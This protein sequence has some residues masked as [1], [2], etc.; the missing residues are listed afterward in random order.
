MRTDAF[1]REHQSLQ[2]DDGEMLER[3]DNAKQVEMDVLYTI[4]YEHLLPRD[5]QAIGAID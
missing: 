2:C 1:G 3:L 4:K 5:F